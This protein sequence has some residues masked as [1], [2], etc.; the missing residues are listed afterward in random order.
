MLLGCWSCAYLPHQ[1]MVSQQVAYNDLS[2]AEAPKTFKA[3][4]VVL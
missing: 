3:Q 2:H 1:E 4:S